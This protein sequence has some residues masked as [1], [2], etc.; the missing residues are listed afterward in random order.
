MSLSS[1]ETAGQHEASFVLHFSSFLLG[2]FLNCAL[3]ATPDKEMIKY[4]GFKHDPIHNPG[5][6]TD[7]KK[8]CQKLFFSNQEVLT[9]L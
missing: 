2:S 4:H 6:T 7:Y 8:L 9:A 5:C 1:M 3:T